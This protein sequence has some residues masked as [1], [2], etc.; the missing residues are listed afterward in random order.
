[1]T[2]Q[3][4]KASILQLAIQGKLVEQRPEEGT[5]EELYKQIQAEK[6]KLIKAGKIKKGKPLPEIT[7]NEIPFDIPVD[8]IWIKLGEI[9]SVLGGK[10]IP[11]GRTLT[12]DNTGY[13]Y[14]RVSDMKNGSVLAE[15]LLYVPTDIYPS[16]SRYV[17]HKEDVYITVAG[18][19][20]RVGKIPPEIDGANLTENADRLVFSIIDQ[21]WLIKC[22]ESSLVQQQIID[23]TTKVGQPKL[24]IKR[25]QELLIPLP[26][27]TEQKRIVAKIE[28]LLPYIDRY[29]KAWNR[30]EEFNKRFPADMQKSI[31]QMA[32]QGKLVEQ[33][34]EEG[35]A[36]ELYKQIQ[37]EK[38]K[39]IK[40][41]KIKKEKPL[42]EITEDEIPFDIPVDWIWI[43]LRDICV[44][45]V[46]GDHNPPSGTKI[47]TEY[48]MLSAQNINN[49]TLVNLEKVRYL[50]KEIFYKENE[51]T[52]VEKGDIFLT[53]VGTLGRSCVY[54]GN[55]NITFQRSVSVI[56]TL[57]H[58]RY[59]KLVFD[60]PY[61]QQYMVSN[62]TGTAQKGFYLH[63]VENLAIPLPPLT[64]QKRIVAK[65][66]EI[67]TLCEKLKQC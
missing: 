34:P 25:I 59:L 24:A 10:R 28:E 42:P 3:E 54:E 61:I 52:K 38:K 18:T 60:S 39:L 51:R 53:T 47:R 6:Q 36:E 5:G 40:A 16:I 63:Q 55:F 30:L 19:I 37:E 41:G 8:W 33:R 9:V 44:K 1:M 11:A 45:I 67:L 58:N 46:D 2:P 65:L 50:T 23:A 31:L 49:N 21:D 29:E 64:E 15:N 22:L 20:G 43:R 26:P 48:L 27:L 57:I 4:L 56:S 35:T 7:E 17:I 14:I 12:A 62:S 32:I 66:E 13:K